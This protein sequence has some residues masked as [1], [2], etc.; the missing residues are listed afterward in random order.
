[1]GTV[2]ILLLAGVAVAAY[3]IGIY[4]TLQRL[5]TQIAAS[6]QEIGN[7]LKRQASL[8]P[9]LEASVKGYLQHEQGIFEKLT[10]ARKSATQASQTN[11]AADIDKAITSMQSL[12]PQ[13]KVLVEDNP[14]LQANTTVMQF[15]SELTD[16]ADKLMYARR[17]VIDLTQQFNEKLV[18]FPS[19]L[20]AG[21]FGFVAEKGLEMPTEGSHLSV[22]AEETKDVTV[23]LTQ[24]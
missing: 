1:M 7:Q 23:D 17:T 4:N 5:K 20:I 18:T 13:I 3:A 9:N 11:S 14:E 12:I 8:I 19:N 16:T 6:I 2:G 24:K 22:S 21:I 10:D 15:M